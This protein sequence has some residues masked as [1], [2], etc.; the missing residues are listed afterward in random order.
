LLAA[1]EGP[2]A[3]LLDI[4]H[5]QAGMQTAALLPAASPD[6]AVALAAGQAG[7]D[8]LP[9]SVFQIRRTDINGL[10]LGFASASPTQIH[11]AAERLAK[12]LQQK[13]PASSQ[14]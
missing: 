7:I 3:G 9:L 1:G 11:D 14:S 6:R 13:K 5:V 12:V 8:V 2:L 4:L 10:L